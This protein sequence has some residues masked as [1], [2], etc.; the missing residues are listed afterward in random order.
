MKFDREKIDIALARSGLTGY[1]QLAKRMGCS[2]Q[3]LSV[4]LTR[5][6]CKPVTAGKIARALG[7]D[8]TEI[9]EEV[10]QA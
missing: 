1:N 8:V 3:N 7:V 6:S 2:V 10:K 9:M 5:G 4:I